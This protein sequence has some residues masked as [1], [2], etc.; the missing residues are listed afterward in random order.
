MSVP[1]TTTTTTAP[2]YANVVKQ[3]PTPLSKVEEGR[4]AEDPAKLKPV[5]A[6]PSTEKKEAVPSSAEVQ[7]P[8]KK[9]NRKKKGSSTKEALNG[10]PTA[11]GQGPKQSQQQAAKTNAAA[12]NPVNRP[13][14]NGPP[15]G[16]PN[17]PVPPNGPQKPPQGGPP[18][19][20]QSANSSGKKEVF[21]T[22]EDY[23]KH[24]QIHV[25]PTAKMI[26]ELERSSIVKDPK[27]FQNPKIAINPHA[28]SSMY[29]ERAIHH[30][31]I[32]E[33]KEKQSLRVL[34]MY[35]SN[36]ME[37]CVLKDPLSLE[38][39]NW[40]PNTIAG[41][42]ARFKR[43]ALV[44]PGDFA[45]V[46]DVYQNGFSALEPE[47]FMALCDATTSGRT[48][49]IMRVFKGQA[50]T[51][52]AFYDEG[53]WT[54]QEGLISFSPDPGSTCYPLHE[55]NGW[56]AKYRSFEG[57]D[58][59]EVTQHGPYTIFLISKTARNAIELSV[60]H[61][62]ENEVEFLET[63]IPYSIG[64]IV[65]DVPD[66][67]SDYV[68]LPSWLKTK[69]S[70]LVHIPTFSSRNHSFR[71]RTLSGT[72]WD[73]TNNVVELAF[74]EAPLMQQMKRRS[75][76]FYRRILEDTVLAII[77]H[78]RTESS[79]QTSSLLKLH[80]VSETRLEQARLGKP[81]ASSYRVLGF[82]AVFLSV[83]KLAIMLYRRRSSQMRDPGWTTIVIACLHKVL[84]F[85][86]YYIMIFGRKLYSWLLQ[87]L[88]VPDLDT[89]R[90]KVEQDP[91]VLSA[92]RDFKKMGE[93]NQNRMWYYGTTLA[94]ILEEGLREISLVGAICTNICE[95]GA[96]FVDSPRDAWVALIFHGAM[97]LA[98]LV[99][100]PLP[101][102]LLIHGTVNLFADRQM[103]LFGTL[104]ELEWRELF[105]NSQAQIYI[106]MPDNLYYT[107]SLIEVPARNSPPMD[108]YALIPS[109]RVKI[110]LGG[111]TFD[112]LPMVAKMLA[113][114]SRPKHLGN[115]T[116][117]PIRQSQ[118]LLFSPIYVF[119]RPART[120]INL[121]NAVMLRTLQNPYTFKTA[122]ELDAF[123][124][125]ITPLWWWI[126]DCLLYH[127]ASHE[128]SPM[129]L[130]QIVK[131]AGKRLER[132][133]LA[134]ERAKAKGNLVLVTKAI[135][136][137]HDE[138]LV[139]RVDQTPEL[140]P[141][142]ITQLSPKYLADQ[143][144]Y[145]RAMADVLHSLFNLDVEYNVWNFHWQTHFQATFTFASGMTA[146]DLSNWMQEATQRPHAVHFIMAGDDLLVLWGP[147]QSVFGL[148]GENDY[149]AYEFTQREACL[150]LWPR[151]WRH[152]GV[153]EDLVEQQISMQKMPYKIVTPV[154]KTETLRLTVHTDPTQQTGC[155][156]TTNIN[157]FNNIGGCYF[158]LAN[159]SPEKGA[160]ECF[161][162][163]GFNSKYKSHEDYT[164][165]TFLKGWW[166]YGLDN[167][168][169]W[170]PLPSMIFKI[171]KTLRHPQEIAKSEDVNEALR[172][173]AYALASSFGEI[174]L[175]YPILGPV[176]D[177]MKRLGTATDVRLFT[178]YER[179][180]RD[181]KFELGAR[182]FSAFH[183]RYG[184][185]YS[186][187]MDFQRV[188]MQVKKLPLVYYHSV[189]DR[190][191]LTTF[192]LL[193]K[194]IS[195]L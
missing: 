194:G 9:R 121:F 73:Q 94:P 68:S 157:T 149:K 112:N 166:Q 151:I 70:L 59:A 15:T 95:I 43:G 135:S 54:R 5:H 159:C 50:G 13:P 155:N 23:F 75:P 11:D 174:P 171:G 184:I 77:V 62:E 80:A 113:E 90:K 84:R 116:F 140:K 56:I 20:N 180:I 136:V 40:C 83:A 139:T 27:I 85:I 137:K 128:L 117:N 21:H 101:L 47:L 87:F 188:I 37:H 71:I 190:Y 189:L 57:L 126:G 34:D 8:K 193:K 61:E 150:T 127:I 41:D 177:R 148:V 176:L 99:G 141:R 172:I 102:R 132:L 39:I 114:I 163:L 18:T 67:L 165:G 53:F 192:R 105:K 130:D 131:I 51:D 119:N 26:A 24:K 89:W 111:Q 195:D 12:G 143:A 58:I 79:E 122:E 82:F 30:I 49:V 191:S 19:Q 170:L 185:A 183:H 142:P 145:S 129:T 46:Q 147:L 63:Q 74:K 31:L 124:K 153:P 103:N 160:E 66:C 104:S 100:V 106:P 45:L 52:S 156:D 133:K 179:C 187:L 1:T 65:C 92:G 10:T 44:V 81:R 29:R 182:V 161:S 178:R 86:K 164:H 6:E 158:L 98:T 17:S 107:P 48:Y 97:N 3:T 109:A 134:S 7:K 173:C 25:N 36:R 146:D 35:G 110:T 72:L 55:D 123:Q 16:P 14:S 168:L 115:E 64:P 93:I 88:E 32:K 96:K 2:T 186:E 28:I 22:I 167:K 42:A 152:F 33:G 69:K 120:P 38:W 125:R 91:R 108:D 144:P 4:P 169:Y 78:K 162:D 175:S 138:T 154:G 60:I 76:R 118:F 181:T